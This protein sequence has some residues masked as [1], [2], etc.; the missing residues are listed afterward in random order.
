[1]TNSPSP[2]APADHCVAATWHHRGM[3]NALPAGFLAMPGIE[4]HARAVLVGLSGGLDSIVLLHL[5]AMQ[6]H[7]R[8]AGLRAIHVHHGLQSAADDWAAHCRVVCDALDL[9]LQV[10]R[11]EVAR[12][13]GTGLEAAARS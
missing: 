7:I 2:C 13:A 6:P 10:V 8:D 3:S 1:R 9:P 4:G 5:L 11:V 12:D